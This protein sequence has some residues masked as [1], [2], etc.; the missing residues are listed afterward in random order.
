M[1]P[2]GTLVQS[3]RG[4]SLVTWVLLRG[5]RLSV[6]VA[7]LGAISLAVLA[8][9]FVFVPSLGS[10]RTVWV[11]NGLVNG[12]LSLITI[13]LTINQLIL[14]RQF[15]SPEDLYERFEARI[16]FRERIEREIDSI[17]VPPQPEDFV[18]TLFRALRGVAHELRLL[19][20]D[21]EDL[22]RDVDE[23]AS[24]IVD[25]TEDVM[26]TLETERFEM[27]GLLAV[28]NYDDTWPLYV[29]RRFQALRGDD[30]SEEVTTRFED[31]RELLKELDTARQY[32]KTLYLQRE[33]A[34]L[35]RRIIVVGSLA[36]V[37]SSLTL[38]AYRNEWVA[39]IG[40][41]GSYLLIT[42]LLALTLSPVA[43]LFSYALRLATV[44]RRTVV[45]GPFTPK[46]EQQADPDWDV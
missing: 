5:G 1:K 13:I 4:K 30:L 14:S 42:V 22:N 17:L 27:L 19:D 21:D 34:L 2:S 25:Q 45:F 41:T 16:E 6:A 44:T 12:L 7:I 8:G 36:I 46:E 40:Q 15:G 24:T 43:V 29:T 37:V 28:L 35:S 32:F 26:E 31:I 20:V 11:F 39:A 23:Y 9:L 33:L 38:F 18:Q 10:E 3:L